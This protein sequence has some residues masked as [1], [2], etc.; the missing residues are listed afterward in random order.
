MP[1][2]SGFG[3]FC[4]IALASE[5]LTQKWTLLVLRELLA[6]SHRFS[7]IR[8]GVPRISSTLL[9][10]RLQSLE[11]AQIVERRRGGQRGV[12][13]YALT[14]AGADLR[15]VLSNIGEWGQRWARDI[16][17]DD[18]DPGWLVWNIHRRLALPAMPPGRTVI[19][20]LFT[21][22]PS[23]QRQFWL[24]KQENRVD[25]C[26]K[27]PGFESDIAVQT[28]V[29]VLAEVWRGIR[30]IRHEIAARRILLEGPPTLRRQFPGW[31]LLSVYAPIKRART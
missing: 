10:Q 23:R 27:P 24:V 16:R 12:F 1:A 21:D 13:E 15:P 18:L 20:I 14:S 3:Q 2:P 30:S 19:E 11:A 4:P 9:K 17:P 5:V 31:L 28:S 8:R 29:R 6:G 7:D 25:V 26:L 22:A